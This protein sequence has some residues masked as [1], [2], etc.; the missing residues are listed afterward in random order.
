M[1][2][3]KNINA[4]TKTQIFLT[5]HSP[6][7]MSSCED[8]FDHQSDKWFDIDCSNGKVS[9]EER[10]FL[11]QGDANTWLKSEAFDLTSSYSLQSEQLIKEAD[12]LRAPLRNSKR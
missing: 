9:L 11:K 10:Q 5:T 1:K 4:Q 6:L 8:Y 3:M 7:V 2:V 12:T